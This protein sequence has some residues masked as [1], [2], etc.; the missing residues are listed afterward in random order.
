MKIL[1]MM[2]EETI[3]TAV[4]GQP[5]ASQHRIQH[6]HNQPSTNIKTADMSGQTTADT[7][8]TPAR[9]FHNSTRVT[10]QQQQP[11][12]HNTTA[13]W[14]RVSLSWSEASLGSSLCLCRLWFGLETRRSASRGRETRGSRGRGSR[15]A[16]STCQPTVS[17]SPTWRGTSA[18]WWMTT[19][20]RRWVRTV[21]EVGN[22][23]H[24]FLNPIDS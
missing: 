24:F 4:G 5:T 13:A 12:H 23:S 6:R 7:P 22:S 20:P 11:T 18:S 16:P 8:P 17:S 3:R 10:T 2:E 15:G 19:S 9:H 21:I 14:Q 1:R